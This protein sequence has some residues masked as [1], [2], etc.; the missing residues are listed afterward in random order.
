MSNRITRIQRIIAQRKAG[1]PPAV[2]P[3][4]RRRKPAP[5]KTW[6]KAKLLEFADSNGIE[7]SST[8]TKATILGKLGA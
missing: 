3:V 8:D 1:K 2:T 6:T 4:I 7:V 5:D